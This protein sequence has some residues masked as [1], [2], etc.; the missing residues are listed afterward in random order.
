MVTWIMWAQRTCPTWTHTNKPRRRKR[1]KKTGFE[2]NAALTVLYVPYS[3]NSGSRRLPDLNRV[4]AE[5]LPDM[6][7]DEATE[8]E[9]EEEVNGI[10]NLALTVLHVPHSGLD[11]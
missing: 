9:E 5:D 7:S 6:D 3:L 8:E 10:R 11:F 2:R 4:G 1:R